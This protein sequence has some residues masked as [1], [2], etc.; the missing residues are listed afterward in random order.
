[1]VCRF[2]EKCLLLG[3][4][5]FLNFSTWLPSAGTTSIYITIH[6]HAANA[7]PSLLQKSQAK[8]VKWMVRVRSRF[9]ETPPMI[10]SALN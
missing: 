10:V 4:P 8:I 1:M 5:L 3:R 9:H 7:Y 6:T 2:S